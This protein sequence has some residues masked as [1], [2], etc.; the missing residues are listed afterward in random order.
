[1]A[2]KLLG[3]GLVPVDSALGRH[4]NPELTLAFPREHQWIALGTGHLDL[5][6]SGAV[7]EKLRTWLAAEPST[8]RP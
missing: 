2:E 5:L 1:M 6:S 8:D 7:Y 4:Q 3:D